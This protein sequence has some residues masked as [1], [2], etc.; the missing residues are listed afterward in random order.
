[1]SRAW[2][3]E[4]IEPEAPLLTNARRVL[5]VRVAEFYSYA[6]TVPIEAASIAH[7]DLRIAT[8]RLRYTLEMFSTV[9]APLGDLQIER[10]KALQE[11]LGDLHDYDVRIAMIEREVSAVAVEQVEAV[12][13]ALAIAPE[14]EH[15]AITTSALRPPPDDPR[16]GLFALLGREYVARREQYQTFVELWRSLEREGMRGDLAT[17]SSFPL[18]G[19]SMRIEPDGSK[20]A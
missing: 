20:G 1:M 19:D 10:T 11:V 12:T 7:H 6:S 4:G 17:L 8:K 15:A 3:V 13:Q 18:G 2:T 16:R 5:R 14:S 9:F